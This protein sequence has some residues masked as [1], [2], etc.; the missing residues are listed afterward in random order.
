MPTEYSAELQASKENAV[1]RFL[2]KPG[3]TGVGVGYKWKDGK[4]TDELVVRVYVEEKK[5]P[6]DV[7]KSRRVPK[8]LAGVETDVIERKFELHQRSMPIELLA[9]PADPGRY[10]PLQG[11]IGIG[12]CRVIDGFVFVGTAGTVVG[13]RGSAS[14]MLLTNFHVAAVDDDFSVGDEIA[15]P[16]RVDGG[17]C[18]ADVVGTLRRAVLSERVDGA[19]VA[20]NQGGRGATCTI[21]DI[22]EVTGTA[23]AALDMNVRKRG[24][25]TGLTFGVVDDLDLT[26]TLEYA[27]GDR[28][29][30]GQ[31]GILVDAGRSQ[32]FGE[33]GDSGSAVVNDANEVVGLYFAG[34]TDGLF[35]IANPIAAVLDELDIDICGTAQVPKPQP[36]KPPIKELKDGFDKPWF[37]EL[38]DAIKFKDFFDGPGIRSAAGDDWFQ[39]QRFAKPKEQEK[40]KEWKEWHKDAWEKYKDVHEGPGPVVGAQAGAAPSGAKAK[41]AKDA[42]ERKEGKEA[43]GG[44][45][46]PPDQRPDLRR[47]ALS[48]EDDS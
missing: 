6:G 2:G 24:R 3:V 47:G 44:H 38:I 26:V 7:P 33:G 9:Q 22:G 13:D 37:K 1:K 10:D 25:T 23:A 19:V 32:K 15:Q 36:D 17:S 12:P 35:G 16:S 30:T 41:E 42:K 14:P 31:I 21:V 39:P 20:L 34:S 48:D 27:V 8:T 28:T 5:P 46:I 4:R 40:F 18:P 11:G 43:D 29:L 45:F